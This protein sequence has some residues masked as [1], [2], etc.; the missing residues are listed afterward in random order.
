[1]AHCSHSHVIDSDLMRSASGEGGS[2]TRGRECRQFLLAVLGD[3]PH[4]VAVTRAILDEWKR[5]R[6]RFGR[7]WLHSMFAHK[8][9]IIL[10]PPDLTE[11]EGAIRSSSPTASAMEAML[12]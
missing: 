1:M 11:I 6:S 4:C 9:V 12:K 7:T 8:L 5:H 2:N 10:E 3:R